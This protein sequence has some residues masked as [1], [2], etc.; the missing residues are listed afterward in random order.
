MIEHTDRSGASADPFPFADAEDTYW[1]NEFRTRPYVR[2]GAAYDEYRDAYRYG[3]ESRASHKAAR[4]WDD[5]SHDLESGW[6][7]AKQTSRLAWNEAKEAVRDGWHHLEKAMP[8]DFD[9][10]GR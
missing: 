10:D 3:W 5:V 4:A 7:K 2:P 8:G 1:R 9:R 6:E